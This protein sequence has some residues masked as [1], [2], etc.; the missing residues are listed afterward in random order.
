MHMKEKIWYSIT[1]LFWFDR[2]H[3]LH[4]YLQWQLWTGNLPKRFDNFFDLSLLKQHQANPSKSFNPYL[5]KWQNQEKQDPSSSKERAWTIYYYQNFD[6]TLYFYS[7]RKVKEEQ[8]HWHFIPPLLLY[9]SFLIT[10]AN[11]VFFFFFC[12]A[13]AIPILVAAEA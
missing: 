1:A 5:Q 13:I 8:V 6:K 11:K 7:L 4:W 10:I 3:V 12:V 9:S 2:M